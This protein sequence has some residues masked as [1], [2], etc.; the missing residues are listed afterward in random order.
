[1]KV[2]DLVKRAYGRGFYQILE[3]YRNQY[4]APRISVLN[5]WTGTVLIDIRPSH[6]KVLN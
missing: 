5:L 1:M 4:N 2:G 6:V 3:I